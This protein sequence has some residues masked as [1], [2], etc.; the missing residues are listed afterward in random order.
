MCAKFHPNP[1]LNL[2]MTCMS[3]KQIY[4]MGDTVQEESI[5]VIKRM[6]TSKPHSTLKSYTHITGKADTDKQKKTKRQ[7]EGLRKKL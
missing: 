6:G 4:E 2:M 1:N 5:K 7:L 3:V